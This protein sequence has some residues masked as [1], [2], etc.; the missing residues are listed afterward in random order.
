MQATVSEGLVQGPN[1]ADG[2]G[3]EHATLRTQDTKLATEPKRLAMAVSIDFLIISANKPIRHLGFRYR[4]G[5]KYK[6][7]ST[8]IGR[9]DMSC[10]H[11]Q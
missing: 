10:A 8:W 5:P 7:A 2:V 4:C 1:V 6:V 9:I 11:A 3:F